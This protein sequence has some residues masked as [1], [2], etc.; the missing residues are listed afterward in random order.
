[1]NEWGF[2][3]DEYQR[4]IGTFSNR[5]RLIVEGKS[6]KYLFKILLDE[7]SLATHQFQKERKNSIDKVD[8][9][10]V[11]TLI[12]SDDSLKLFIVDA[13][14]NRQK[15]E[16]IH[17]NVKNLPKYTNL[18]FFVDREFDNFTI[19]FEEEIKDEM[20]SHKVDGALIWSRGHSIE[21]YL[22]D[23]TILH[24]PLRIL[25]DGKLFDDAIKIFEDNFYL[26]IRLA[27]A[28]SIAFKECEKIQ[29]LEK[30][31]D[32][33]LID[34]DTSNVNLRIVDW[35]EKMY[36]RGEQDQRGR[37][38]RKF[39]NEEIEQ[40]INSYQ[41]WYQKIENDNV[42]ESILR[43]ICHGHIGF[44]V[45]LEVYCSCVHYCVLNREINNE[46]NKTKDI[47]KVYREAN[48]KIHKS[49]KDD[50][51]EQFANWWAHKA[52]RNEC[53]YPLEVLEKLGII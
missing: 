6:D 43:W 23:S 40:I 4:A 2:K 39:S 45:I 17:K 49:G 11:E 28:V 22:F 30:I 5:K 29:A 33:E 38:I 14:G 15:I 18:V 12:K 19:S 35:R 1:M 47:N 37:T 16:R 42:D 8:I 9:D 52:V 7:F 25:S 13:A 21:N 34:I 41:M 51:W 24:Q 50:I 46:L 27:S 53:L 20:S 36:K 44:Q 31:I 3:I 10:D 32:W 48:H 26:T